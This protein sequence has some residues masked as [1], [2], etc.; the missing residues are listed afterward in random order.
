M[1]TSPTSGNICVA[2]LS[3]FSISIARL[4][5]IKSRAPERSSDESRNL[6]YLAAA[7]P[8]TALSVRYF[9][10]KKSDGGKVNEQLEKVQKF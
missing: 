1:F 8:F 7:L 3:D 10:I 5:L 9:S 2:V 4:P 6:F